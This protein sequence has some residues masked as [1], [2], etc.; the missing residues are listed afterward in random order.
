M[1]DSPKTDS[2]RVYFESPWELGCCTSLLLPTLGPQHSPSPWGANPFSCLWQLLFSSWPI[3]FY[4]EHLLAP[5][6]HFGSKIQKKPPF[7]LP[8][9][10]SHINSGAMLVLWLLAYFAVHREEPTFVINVAHVC[11]VSLC[12]CCQF[13]CRNSK[14][15]K[16]LTRPYGIRKIFAGLL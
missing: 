13:L 2:C 8:S 10:S 5:Q 12:G 1:R 6:G 14:R 15:L 9:F 3:M 7:L 11:L 4:R 16:N